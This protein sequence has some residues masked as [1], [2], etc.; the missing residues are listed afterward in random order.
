MNY[1]KLRYFYTVAQTLNFTKAADELFVS[2]SAISRH[3]KEL[4]EDFGVSLF[5]RTNRD[6]IL[7]DAGKTLFEEIQYLF[8][9]ENEIY[10]K[11]RAAAFQEVARLNI[12]FMGIKPA[13]HI[14]A[15]VNQMLLEHSSLSINL[16]RYNW[17]DILPALNCNEIDVGLRL[18]MGDFTETEYN[19]LVLDQAYP[20]MVVSSRHPMA[21]KKRAVLS[22]FKND[23]FL[24]LSKKDSAIPYSYTKKLFEQYGFS[25]KSYSEYDQVETIL[26][27]IHS[28]AG[29]SLLSRFAAT[30]QFPDLQVIELDQI[31]ALYLELVWKKTN[32]NPFISIF[33]DKLNMYDYN[34]CM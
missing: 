2:Q 33:A 24:M 29:V 10:Q 20:A 6:L 21:Q 13:Y 5:V 8:S 16:R 30:D 4:E 11:V 9:R 19:H 7:T 22:A 26:M 18:R 32:S 17:D 14:P 34:D 12:G 31:D 15:I 28:N 1:N 3:M 27:L 23:M 25:P